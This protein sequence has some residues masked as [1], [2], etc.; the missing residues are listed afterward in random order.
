M[1]RNTTLSLTVPQGFDLPRV[2][3]S[4]GY[5]LL[6]PNRWD[7]ARQR[8]IRPLQLSDRTVHVLVDQPSRQSNRLRVACDQPVPPQR[9]APLTRQLSR[10]LRLDEDL[11]HWFQQNPN[12]RAE[13]FGRLFRSPT[14]FEDIVKTIT[15][16]NVAWGNTMQMNR[17]LCE[18]IGGGRFPEVEELVAVSPKTLQDE[19]KVGYRA[20]RIVRLAQRVASGD[21]QLEWFGQPGRTSEEAFTALRRIHGIGP[22]AA[23]NVCQHLGFYDQLPIDSETQRHFCRHFNVERPGNPSALH[24]RIERHYNQ[25]APHQFLAYW[26]ELWRDYERKLGPAWRWDVSTGARVTR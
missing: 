8:L 13:G 21:L 25:F 22:Y 5:F 26:Y 16:C 14:L 18:R 19:T 6:A 23:A 20:E 15:G 10:M 24:H 2:V 1:A 7:V 9:R 17:L 3:C 12:A 4:Y 11:A